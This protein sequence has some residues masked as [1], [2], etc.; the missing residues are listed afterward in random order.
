M[1]AY[2][3]YKDLIRIAAKDHFWAYCNHMDYEF[4]QKRRFLKDIA[5]LF[6]KVYDNYI[7]GVVIDV[8]A[9]LPPR[10]GKS[11][12]T[13]L[14]S[15][16]WLGKLPHHSVMRNTCTSTLYEK[17]SYDT[18]E[19]IKS[20]KYRQIFPE[21]VISKNK[22]NL[23]G[24]NTNFAIQVSYFGGGVGSTII[25]FGANLAIN[26]DLYKSMEDA[27]SPKTNERVELWKQSAHDS[28]KEKNCPEIYIG[29]RWTKEDVIGKAIESG[30]V[31]PENTVKQPALVEGKSFCEEV[32]TTKEYLSIKEDIQEEVWEAEY[33]Q[34]P[35]EIK[36]LLFP[37]T[38]TKNFVSLP[39][40]P[41]MILQ[42]ID[43]ADEGTNKLCSKIYYIKDTT[44]FNVN[45]IYTKDNVDITEPRIVEQ[46][47][48]YKP[49]YTCIES[50][51][52]WRLFGRD[53]KNKL[54][55][56]GLDTVVILYNQCKNKE[57]RIFNHAPSVANNFHYLHESSSSEE[58]TDEYKDAMKEKHRYK[59][60]I[61]DQND[62]SCDVDAAAAE[63]LKKMGILPIA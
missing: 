51:G 19:I 20:E 56:I 37:P 13:S 53:I 26:D 9:S 1:I 4:F 3:E 11:Y 14:F 58:N 52:A 38:K 18:R 44:I 54:D 17:F 24:W 8:A 43:P 34:N 30:K 39:S 63:W 27:L 12:L 15:S 5:L 33:M 48:K 7:Q 57:I 23:N 32:K 10:S 29:T 21:V 62:D 36:G 46:S 25:G 49:A 6:Q 31:L 61:K 55:E 45:T 59:K 47:V 28:R 60:M 2:N 42:W 40:D 50:N 41:D 35:I 22:S 16:W